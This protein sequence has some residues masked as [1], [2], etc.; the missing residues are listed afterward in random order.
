HKPTHWGTAFIA[1]ATESNQ[2][3]LLSAFELIRFDILTSKEYSRS[4]DVPVQDKHLGDSAKHIR[5]ISRTVSLVPMTFKHDVPFVGQMYRDVLVFNSFVK[6][7]NRSYRNLCEMLL[8]SLFL[9][10]CV[11]RDRRDYAE[12]SIRLPYVSDINAATGMVAKSYLENTLKEESASK[13]VETTEKMYSTAI[14]LKAGLA[15]GFEFWDQVMKG[16]K[17]LKAAK[18]FESTCDMFLEADAWLQGRRF[19]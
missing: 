1:A 8:L 9:N 2:E 5:L 10:D 11:K 19:P 6:A 7:L 18:S 4:Y 13:A 17:V 16:I 12:L 3:A 15:N 14:D